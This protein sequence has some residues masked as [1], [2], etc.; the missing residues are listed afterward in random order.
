MFWFKTTN[1]NL[2]SEFNTAKIFT[3]FEE[4]NI[5]IET[6]DSEARITCLT[7]DSEDRVVILTA[8]K[9]PTKTVPAINRELQ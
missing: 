3:F 8:K 4:V 7:T 5:Q 6:S 1:R 2:T 9:S